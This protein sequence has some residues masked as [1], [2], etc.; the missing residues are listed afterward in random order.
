[1]EGQMWSAER[2]LLYDTIFEARPSV[3]LEIGTWKGG[4][5]T[6]QIATALSDLQHGVLYTCEINTPFYLEAAK[7]YSE[8]RW[9]GIVKCYNISSTQL[10]NQL[11]R[12]NQ[13]PD[14]IFCD[15]PEDPD[16]NLSDFLLLEP[17]L[18]SGAVFCVHDWNMDVREGGVIS[19]KAKLLRPYIENSASWKIQ[20]C[21][22]MPESVGMAVAIK[23]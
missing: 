18:R 15:G 7:I 6:Y 21:L 22:T 10:I 23:I 13:I 5:S 8:S 17:Y 9:Q 12:N 2:R 3:S 14:F 16:L 4:G 1:M 11:I 19:I 20:T